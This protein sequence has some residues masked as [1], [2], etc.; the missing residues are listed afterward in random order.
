MFAAAMHAGT[1]HGEA[2]LEWRDRVVGGVL[3]AGT[4]LYLSRWPYNLGSSD[5]GIYLYQAKRLLAGDVFFRDIF[6]IIPPG[7]HYLMAAAY[8]LF[9]T[10]MTTAR[11]LNALVHAAMAV[12]FYAGT[13]MIGAGIVL[14]L[15]P[16]LAHLALC[17]APWPFASPHWI[18]SSLTL[19]A[20]LLALRG[21]WRDHD[22]AGFALGLVIGMLIMVQQQKGVLVAAGVH[23]LV[24]LLWALQAGAPLWRQMLRIDL[25][26]AAVVVPAFG[27]LAL[28][29]GVA[30]IF[31][32]L[33]EHTFVNYRHHH[34]TGWGSVPLMTEGFAA[35]TFPLLLKYAPFVLVPEAIRT[36]ILC[37]QAN[38]PHAARTSL[39][40]VLFGLA[41]AASIAYFPDFIH[42]GFIAGLFFI[43]AVTLLHRALAVARWSAYVTLLAGVAL[44]VALAVQLG[45][46]L[47]RSQREFAITADT[48]FGRIAF[49]DNHQPGFVH[50]AEELLAGNPSREM[51][52]YPFYASLY[53]MTSAKNPTPYQFLYPR[54]S[55]AAQIQEVIGILDARR[56]PLV[57]AFHAFVPKDDTLMTYIRS[58]YTP[59]DAHQ[60]FWTRRPD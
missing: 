13:R 32:A 1:R 12:G 22:R 37:W 43:A 24:L 48:A 34:Q 10:S 20:F 14:S 25:G 55:G 6:D 59:A 47:T 21:R 7:A 42:I 23:V 29:A 2:A 44:S 30:P 16:P 26:I 3:F 46:N 50:T 8:W 53:L 35:Y 57:F 19:A 4:L 28:Q 56:V 54:Y 41:T 52:T 11:G 5:E 18:A 49:A 39:T 60:L 31:Y 33:V 38:D 51:F 9:G 15:V 17:Q 58:R 36:L 40:L 45:R 27:L